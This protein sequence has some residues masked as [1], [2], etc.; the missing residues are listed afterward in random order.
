MNHL[1]AYATP[2]GTFYI[3]RVAGRYLTMFESRLLNSY[4]TAE[5]AALMLA[6]S[7]QLSF[8]TGIKFDDLQIPADLRKWEEVG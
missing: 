3:C 1:Y 6:E 8:P 4:E 5:F 7:R 2:A